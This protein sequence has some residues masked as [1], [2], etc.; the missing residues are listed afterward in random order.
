MKKPFL[1]PDGH[2]EFFK[3]LRELVEI[4]FGRRS[5]RQE[6][7][8]ELTAAEV[9]AAPTAADHNKLVRDVQMLRSYVKDTRDRFNDD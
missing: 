5:N 9:S 8:P 1:K 4:A 3:G 2:P 6:P 7:V